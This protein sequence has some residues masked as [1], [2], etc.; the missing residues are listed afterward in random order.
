MM[1]VDQSCRSEVTVGI[2]Y[3]V[4]TAADQLR[5]AV[6]SILSQT[7]RPCVVHLVQ[8]GVVSRE[9]QAL[10]ADYV[11]SHAHVKHLMIPDNRGL[12]YALNLSI[13]NTSTEFYARMDADD[14]SHPERLGKQVDYLRKHPDI[15]ILGTWVI[16][17]AHEPFEDGGFVKRLPTDPAAIAAFFHYRNPLAHPSVMFRRTVFARIGL[18]DTEFRTDQDLALWGRALKMGVGISNL[19]EV[20]LFHRARDLASRRS[21]W[22]RVRRQARARYSYNTCS[23]LLNVL[24]VFALLFRLLPL[25]VRVWGYRHLR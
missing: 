4:G 7:L 9:V 25:P 13:L 23:P 16:E 20:L 22:A 6:D 2:P 3:H 17:F 12:P 10:A 18:Y 8:D 19:P 11:S 24:K 21:T 5:L 1:T 14:V 15:D